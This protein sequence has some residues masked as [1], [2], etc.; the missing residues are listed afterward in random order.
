MRDGGEGNK[1]QSKDI[2][3]TAISKGPKDHIL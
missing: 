3:Q 2:I 1:Y